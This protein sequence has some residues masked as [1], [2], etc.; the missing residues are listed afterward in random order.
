MCVRV[1]ARCVT[2]YDGQAGPLYFFSTVARRWRR[3][4]ARGWAPRGLTPDR[5][6]SRLGA[7]P[8]RGVGSPGFAFGVTSTNRRPR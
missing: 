8:S 7:K 1:R 2:L 4:P 5:D 6:A 3:P